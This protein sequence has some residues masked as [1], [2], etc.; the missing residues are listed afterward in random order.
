MRVVLSNGYGFKRIDDRNIAVFKVAKRKRKDTNEEYD[1]DDILGYHPVIETAIKSIQKKSQIDLK[2]NN[3]DELIE[4][5][6]NLN[7]TIIEACESQ[8][9][10]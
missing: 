9:N 1:F 8:L 2:S 5:I 4:E 3:I 7:K 10:S 6:K